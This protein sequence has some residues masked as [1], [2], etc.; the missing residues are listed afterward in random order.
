MSVVNIAFPKLLVKPGWRKRE[1]GKKGKK[2]QAG[3]REI[4]IGRVKKATI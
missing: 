2:E 3:G 4:L 1:E